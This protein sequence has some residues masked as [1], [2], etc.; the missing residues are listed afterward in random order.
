MNTW[1]HYWYHNSADILGWVFNPGHDFDIFLRSSYVIRRLC[2]NGIAA[3]TEME[4][5]CAWVA[6]KTCARWTTA[7]QRTE[8]HYYMVNI[9]TKNWNRSIFFF[10]LSSFSG[11]SWLFF[12]IAFIRTHETRGLLARSHSFILRKKMYYCYLSCTYIDKLNLIWMGVGEKNSNQSDMVPI[13]EMGLGQ[14]P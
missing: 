12:L 9:L 3:T 2:T 6:G 8:P 13:E 5:Q 4:V 1:Y 11:M 14:K 7:R 10:L